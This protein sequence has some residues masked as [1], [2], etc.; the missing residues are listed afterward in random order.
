MSGNRWLP[1]TTQV[2][3]H[4]LDFIASGLKPG[5]LRVALYI[6]RR[7]YGFQ[8]EQ[9]YVSLSQLTRGIVRR[10]GTRQDTGTGLTRASV[11]AA[12]EGLERRGLLAVHRR[13]G[14]AGK[15]AETT[16][17][18][19]NAALFDS[20]ATVPA[21]GSI[22]S[23]PPPAPPS[24][25]NE[26]GGSSLRGTGVVHLVNPQNPDVQ[27]QE[28]QNDRSPTHIHAGAPG[29]APAPVPEP[30]LTPPART[31]IN[32]HDRRDFSDDNTLDSPRWRNLRVD[33]GLSRA[34]LDSRVKLARRAREF[35]T[36]K[37][38]L[39]IMVSEELKNA[40][41]LPRRTRR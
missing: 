33:H 34:D 15:S 30:D 13:P 35:L 22:G 39:F 23:E 7:T 37:L 6:I 1:N 17:Y 18:S 31:G 21:G 36:V 19:L 25:V 12:V 27:N 3:N 2:P 20:D 10:D 26:P 8:K 11:V 32:P 5:E 14:S 16:S 9:D 38:P 40:R 28:A 4:F 41:S 29:R 24:I